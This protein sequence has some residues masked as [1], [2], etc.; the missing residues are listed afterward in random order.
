M[1]SVS[2]PAKH[3][4]AASSLSGRPVIPAIPLPHVKRQAAAAANR[5]ANVKNS[6][7]A[8]PIAPENPV[9]KKSEAKAS[10]TTKQTPAGFTS[11]AG[12]KPKASAEQTAHQANEQPVTAQLDSAQDKAKVMAPGTVSPMVSETQPLLEGHVQKASAENDVN[13]AQPNAVPAQTNGLHTTNSSQTSSKSQKLYKL[14]F[15]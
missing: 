8:T 14:H 13:V 10:N 1:A 7:P 5:S 6:R 2:G 9:A 4:K 3:R 11:S 12:T 15:R